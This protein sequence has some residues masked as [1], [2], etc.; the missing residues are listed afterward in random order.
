MREQRR[1]NAEYA[2]RCLWDHSYFWQAFSERSVSVAWLRGRA[3]LPKNSWFMHRS[4]LMRIAVTGSVGG[5]TR[6]YRRGIRVMCSR[7]RRR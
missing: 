7:Q 1:E 6:I 4:S 3:S 5:A 2:L